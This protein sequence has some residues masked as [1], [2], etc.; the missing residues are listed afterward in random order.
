VRDVLVCADTFQIL[1]H[2]R[3]EPERAEIF[4]ESFP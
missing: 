4:F 2:G 3:E 1:G